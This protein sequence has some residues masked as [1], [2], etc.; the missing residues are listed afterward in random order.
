MS[1]A[2][3]AK[4][5]TIRR[6]PDPDP[7]PSPSRSTSRLPK[8]SSLRAL[9]QLAGRLAAFPARPVTAGGGI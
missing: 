1:G 5:L 6:L 9:L 7:D 3:L 4:C 2:V 8:Y